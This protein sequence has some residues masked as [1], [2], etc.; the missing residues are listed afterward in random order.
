[1][2][3]ELVAHKSFRTLVGTHAMEDGSTPGVYLLDTNNSTDFYGLF[4]VFDGDP[5][6][7]TFAIEHVKK[8]FAIYSDVFQRGDIPRPKAFLN[9]LLTDLHREMHHADM[10]LDQRDRFAACLVKEGKIVIGR[11]NNFPVF[12]MR[13]H[14]ERRIFSNKDSAGHI[15]VAEENLADGDKVLFTTYETKECRKIIDTNADVD[16]AC[17]R[18]NDLATRHET[19]KPPR[20]ALISFKRNRVK[21]K[22][23][24]NVKNISLLAFMALFIMAIVFWRETS[25]IFRGFQSLSIAKIFQSKQPG[26]PGGGSPQNPLYEAEVVLDTLAVPYDIAV[27]S[28]GILYV[29]DDKESEIVRYDP[30]TKQATLIGN[31]L[32]LEFPTGI[33]VSGDRIFVADYSQHAS[34][35]NIIKTSG[36]KIGEIKSISS[37]GVGGLSNP[38]AVAADKQGNIWLAD[39]GNNR[40]IKFS[41]R[42]EFMGKMDFPAQFKMP[43]GIAFAGDGRIYVTFK[44]SNNIATR[45]PNGKLQSFQ[46]TTTQGK[47]IKFN[48][49][50]GIAVDDKGF[51]Y[52]T[53]RRNN[54]IVV[55]DSR[56]KV[57][58]IIDEKKYSEFKTFMPFGLKIGEKGKYLYVVGSTE[59]FFDRSCQV[60][61]DKCRGKIWRIRI[62]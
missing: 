35:F 34:S 3:R 31:G 49:P 55:T 13:D 21:N 22:A 39:R 37:P 12:F 62:E 2:A 1:M 24:L 48:Q 42:G 7:T 29:V 19:V 25:M 59:T 28:H 4:F 14:K 17:A 5:A 40:L 57:D 46:V 8:K 60:E 32:G 38:K 16:Q 15:K 51:V 61:K 36:Q 50:S 43:N 53:D 56:G 58:T 47:K 11:Y 10:K 45:A 20:M 44:D 52:V 26:G 27:D 33:E 54:R 18:I 9:E 30:F 6:K 23:L 41:V